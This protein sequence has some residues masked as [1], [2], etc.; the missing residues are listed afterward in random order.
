M[1]RRDRE[2]EWTESGDR[3]LVAVA[4][5]PPKM[6]PS[7]GESGSG[8]WLWRPSISPKIPTSCATILEGNNFSQLSLGFLFIWICKLNCLRAVSV[9]GV[10]Y[11]CKLCLTLHN[12][13][14]NYLAHT[15]GKRHQTN[16]AKRAAREAKDAP[17]QPQPH[18]RKVSVRKT[19]FVSILCG[20]AFKFKLVN[21]RCEV[22]V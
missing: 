21:Y 17:A 1:N 8:G 15:Q 18:K 16:L 10:S 12:N 7:I 4:P 9:H 3:S 5:P 6:K 22:C 13:E 14:G 2:I 11:E 19:G 20:F